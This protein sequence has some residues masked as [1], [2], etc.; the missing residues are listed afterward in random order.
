MQ[1]MRNRSTLA[2]ALGLALASCSNGDDTTV[3][4]AVTPITG[5]STGATCPESSDLSY[6][7]FGQPFFQAYCLRCHTAAISGP[8]R[9]APLDRDFDD[10]AMIRANAYNIDQMT[11]AGPNGARQVMPPGDNKP[12]LEQRTQLSEWLACGAP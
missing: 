1:S 11:G 2:V 6:A 4:D 7:S 3:P 5:L 12:S 10:V 8:Q 9:Q